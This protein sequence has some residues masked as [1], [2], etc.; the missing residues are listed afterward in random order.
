MTH[1]DEASPQ[2]YARL[3]GWLYLFI[4]VAG[5]FVELFVRDAPVVS[6]DPD[7]TARNILASAPLY[8]FGI[9]IE[10]VWL[11]FAIAITAILYVLLKP[12]DKLLALLASFLNLVSISVEAVSCVILLAVMILVGDASYLKPFEPAQLHALAYVG[13]KVFDN[14]FG[15]TLVFFG[16]CLLTYGW[17]IVRSGFLPKTIGV[18]LAVAGVAYLV[19]SFTLFLAPALASNIFPVLVLAFIGE[20]SFCLWLIVKGVDVPTW[21]SRAAEAG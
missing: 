5:I 16:C 9:A 17:L 7:A 1:N 18:L 10:L 6:G 14:G 3:A 8:R 19:N 2:V 15:V 12:V 20:T 21:R 13:L 4:I 11:T